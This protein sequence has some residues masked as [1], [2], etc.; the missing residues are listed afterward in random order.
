M[1]FKKLDDNYR[2]FFTALLFWLFVLLSIMLKIYI[3][4]EKLR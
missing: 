1:K 4:Y 2:E 3:Y